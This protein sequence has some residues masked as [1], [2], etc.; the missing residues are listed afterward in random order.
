MSM[1]PRTNFTSAVR[2]LVPS[3]KNRRSPFDVPP[4][5]K[6]TMTG[7]KPLR[8]IHTPSGDYPR[9]KKRCARQQGRASARLA[10]VRTG[11]HAGSAIYALRAMLCVLSLLRKAKLYNE[12]YSPSQV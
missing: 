10:D 12:F 4:L 11:P 2:K 1:T 3:G 8:C 6:A 7:E 5:V 9:I